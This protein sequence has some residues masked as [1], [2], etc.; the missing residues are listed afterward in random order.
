VKLSPRLNSRSVRF[1]KW[2]WAALLLGSVA[3]TFAAEPQTGDWSFGWDGLVTVGRWTPATVGFT[4]DAPAEC[5]VELSALDA[6][7]HTAT[8]VSPAVSLPAGSQR[9][10]G[11]CQIGRIDSGLRGRLLVGGLVS[12]EVSLRPGQREQLRPLAKLADRVIVTVGEPQGFDRLPRGA[13]SHS[14]PAVHVISRKSPTDLPTEPRSYDSV[15]WLVLTG[16]EPV[17]G[18]VSAAL[19][20]W[21]ADGGRLVISLPKQLAGFQSSPLREW[22]PVRVGDEPVVV[23][24]LGRLADMAG[25]SIKIPSTTGREPVARMQADEGISLAS[26]RETPL[27]LR[28]PYGFGEVFVLGMDITQP[29]L[30]IWGGLPNFVRNLLEIPD[31][32]AANQPQSTGPRAAQLTSTGISDLA[33]QVHACQD[34]FPSV[35]RASPWWAMAWM[36]GLLAIVGPLDYLLVHR[37]LQRPQATWITLPVWLIAASVL[38]AR[39]AT[40]WNTSEAQLHQLDVID[41]AGGSQRLRVQ[42]WYTLY[43]PDT[44]RT[45]FAVQP[46]Y[47]DAATDDRPVQHSVS[48]AAIPETVFGG[49]YRPGGTEWGRTEYRVLAQDHSVRQLPLL[50]WSSRT[51]TAE[52][53]RDGDA[54]ATSELHG[55]GLGRLTGQVTHHLPGELTEWILAYGTRAYRRQPSREDETSVPWPANETWDIEHPLVFQRELRGVLTRTVM[56]RESTDGRLANT[57]IRQEQ[58]RYD[59]LSRDPT[60]VWQ[61]LTFHEAAGG[62][63]YSTLTNHLLADRDLSRQLQLGRAVLF[64]RLSPASG[65]AVQREGQAVTADRHDTFVRLV[66]PVRRSGEVVRELPKFKR[67]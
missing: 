55:T 61:L 4:L 6:E 52:W 20:E 36:L 16:A 42:S 44:A 60:S 35:R 40:A 7:G 11:F 9:L 17:P 58:S 24:D 48:W 38:A 53:S 56:M 8:F 21:V 15:Q 50:Q 31:A 47:F 23:L 41:S 54:L 51:L 28:V 33:S 59:P 2:W 29:P 45:D 30:V 32:T 5:Q 26:S 22:L 39:S 18:E 1:V 34:R 14:D 12:E 43:N 49:L 62:T 65:A 46:S 37:V 66:L 57:V 19:R 63:T 25:R 10:T 64:G 3:P 13:A 67:D 27:L